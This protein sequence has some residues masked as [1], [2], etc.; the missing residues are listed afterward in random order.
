MSRS[1]LPPRHFSE[2][3][4]DERPHSMTNGGPWTITVRHSDSFIEYLRADQESKL[5]HHIAVLRKHGYRQRRFRR[6]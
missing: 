6:H 2:P 1:E 5:Q 3:Y 4:L